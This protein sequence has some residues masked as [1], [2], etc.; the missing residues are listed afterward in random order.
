MGW[1][2]GIRKTIT[3]RTPGRFEKSIIMFAI[4][5][6]SASIEMGNVRS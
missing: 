2:K 5:G 1:E 6:T 4:I 3:L